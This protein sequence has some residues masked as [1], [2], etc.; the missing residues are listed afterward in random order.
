MFKKTLI[1]LAVASSLGLTGC[2]SGS[3]SG[4]N[5]NPKPQY[6]GDALNTTYPL[7]NPA[8]RQIPT[9][10]DLSFS[11][12]LDGTFK[13]D[14]TADSSPVEIALDSLSGASTVDP[15]TIKTSGQIDKSSLKPNQ[16]IF[17]I[18]VKYASGDPI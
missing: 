6:A 13:L 4:G 15:I 8:K 3:N 9:P 14:L 11:G 12:S 16:N 1:S 17:L 10:T 5:D 18:P 7:F 2:F